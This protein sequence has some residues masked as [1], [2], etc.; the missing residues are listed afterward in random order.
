[1]ELLRKEHEIILEKLNTGVI[2]ISKQSN[3]KM[4]SYSNEFATN[5][6]GIKIRNIKRAKMSD[7]ESTHSSESDLNR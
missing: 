4:M 6:F 2:T 1:V 5:L 3:E 7:G